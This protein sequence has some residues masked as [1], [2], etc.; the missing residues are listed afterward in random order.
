MVLKSNEIHKQLIMLDRQY[1]GNVVEAITVY[2]VKT[3]QVVLYINK[4]S[5]SPTATNRYKV[6]F[7]DNQT[8]EYGETEILFTVYPSKMID[9][10]NISG[11]SGYKFVWN[12]SGL[13][14][15]LREIVKALGSFY[16]LPICREHI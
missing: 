1:T 14:R 6:E 2:E 3:K 15:S 16:N 4:S 9:Y 8:G 13:R 10:S 12:N 7:K 5:L 11:T